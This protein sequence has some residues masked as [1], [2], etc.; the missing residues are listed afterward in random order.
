MLATIIDPVRS[1]LHP[2]HYQGRGGPFV[3]L[4][5]ALIFFKIAVAI[6][7]GFALLILFAAGNL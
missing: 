5:V 1:A 7:I 6:V 3:R 2:V 4:F